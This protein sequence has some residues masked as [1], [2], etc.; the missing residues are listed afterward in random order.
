[1]APEGQVS[2]FPA[3]ETEIQRGC[4][5]CLLSPSYREYL[6]KAE[7]GTGVT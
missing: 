3:E 2:G 5:I 1:M 7:V 4:V 6:T